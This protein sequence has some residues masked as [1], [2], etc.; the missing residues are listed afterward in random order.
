MFSERATCRLTGGPQKMQDPILSASIRPRRSAPLPSR[1]SCP[2][3]SSRLD[4]RT[5]SGSGFA[6]SRNDL[7][8]LRGF[9][10]G[11]GSSTAL[12]CAG[13][14]SVARGLSKLLDGA[15]S[16]RP[17]LL[18]AVVLEP[19]EV[20]ATPELR[21]PKSRCMLTT[22]CVTKRPQIGLCSQMVSMR[23]RI[24]EWKA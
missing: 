18:C 2:T 13:F 11:L 19:D 14:D 1:C 22:C 16:L 5:I 8:L 4:G 6:A 15:G 10:A 24:P 7:L 9:F 20:E 17:R 3:K 12:P 21:Q 23:D